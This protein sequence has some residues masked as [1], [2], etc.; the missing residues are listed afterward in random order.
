MTWSLIVRYRLH[1]GNLLSN[2]LLSELEKSHELPTIGKV[3]GGPGMFLRMSP[4]FLCFQRNQKTIP[5]K[6]RKHDKY[7][8]QL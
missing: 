7:I 4:C 6:T 3:A 2:V 1:L 5:R 8:F